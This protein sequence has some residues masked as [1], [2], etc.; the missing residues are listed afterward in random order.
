[1]FKIIIPWLQSIKV[2]KY[3]GRDNCGFYYLIWL[4]KPGIDK[5]NFIVWSPVKLESLYW[6]LSRSANHF[7]ICCVTSREGKLS[8]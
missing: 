8:C 6:W 7:D 3:P 2:I 4:T 5:S 1:M